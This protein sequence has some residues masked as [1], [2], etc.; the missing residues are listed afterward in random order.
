MGARDGQ[1]SRFIF[2]ELKRYVGVLLQK[3]VPLVDAD[4]ND[5]VESFTT[6]VRRFLEFTVGSGSPNAGFNIEEA[7]VSTNDFT[8]KGGDGT[9]EGAGRIF[10]AGHHFF[11]IPRSTNGR[12]RSR[13]YH[14]L[15]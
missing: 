2:D 6:Q 4:L 1:Y 11:A 13:L 15:K 10:V 5:F 9:A 12:K 14:K 7:S 3:N 8:V